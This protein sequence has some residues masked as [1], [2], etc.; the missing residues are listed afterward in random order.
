M[1]KSFPVLPHIVEPRRGGNSRLHFL[2]REVLAKLRRP[3]AVLLY[4]LY[5][6]RFFVYMGNVDPFHALAFHFSWNFLNFILV[7]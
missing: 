3:L 1:L 6:S 4:R 7:L 2:Y 5:R